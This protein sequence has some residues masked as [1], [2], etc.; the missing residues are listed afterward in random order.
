MKKNLLTFVCSLLLAGSM[1]AGDAKP[2]VVVWYPNESGE[3]LKSARAAIDDLISKAV[4][5]P[6]VDKLT[7]D[8]N[9]AIETM[10][11]NNGAF[12][13]PGAQGYIEARNKNPKLEPLVTN[14]GNSGT[15]T[16]AVYYS[17]IAVRSA[18]AA[19]YYKDGKYVLDGIQGKKFS[20]VSTSSTSGF[21]VPSK[22]LIKYFS[23]KGGVL[24]TLKPEDLLEGGA[25]KFFSLVLFGQSHQGSAVN[26]LT[27]KVD[28]AA[29][30]DVNTMN[31][32]ELFSGTANQPGAVYKVKMNADDPFSSL[33]GQTWTILASSPVL[34]A[35]MVINTNFFS[36][37]EIAKLLAAFTSDAVAQNPAI[38]APKGSAVKA[39]FEQNGKNRFVK[40]DDAF[41]NPI[42]ALSK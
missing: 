37:E 29:F 31:Y 5:R 3:E 32:S 36:K 40:V 26:L 10:A 34:N 7:T 15:L 11:S 22:S 38:F 2:L 14:S 17:W 39:M 27:G 30:N 1:F 18:D 23:A 28:A 4:G 6:V 21:K 8:Y 13:F 9:I 33:G 20:W 12:A 24:A 25:G 16:D 19:K 42:R 41:Y 35:P